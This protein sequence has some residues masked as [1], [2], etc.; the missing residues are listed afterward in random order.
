[1]AGS[2]RL[3]AFTQK[4]VKAC[5]NEVK[6]DVAVSPYFNAKKTGGALPEGVV[7]PAEMGAN[8]KRF[9]QKTG[10]SIVMLQDGVGVGR[11]PA[12]EVEAYVRPYLVAVAK[13]CSEASPPRG[14]KIRFWLN[15]ESIGA[16]MSRLKA[17]LTL[18]AGSVDKI[19]TFDFPCYL[20]RSPLYE[21]YLRYLAA[22]S[23][24]AP[25]GAKNP[26]TLGKSSPELEA[27]VDAAVKNHMD[28]YDI[29]GVSI[30]LVRDGQPLIVKGYGLANVELGT[31]RGAVD[32]LRACFDLKDV[33]R[34]R[35]HDAGEGR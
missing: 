21:D 17:Q 16:D 2:H 24:T 11:I 15:V 32:G 34:D 1:M 27:A 18:G 3:S 35:G 22:E 26:G 5:H 13:A 4:L 14:P 33:H 8:Y 23:R 9:L 6:K 12:G 25:K 31:D 29:P 7:G 10:L 30:A 20:G 28:R 19:V